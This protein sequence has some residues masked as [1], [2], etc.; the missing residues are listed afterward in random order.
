MT[1]KIKIVTA[2]FKNK[3]I[4]VND[5]K[6]IIS[7]DFQA[8]KAVAFKEKDITVNSAKPVIISKFQPNKPI[9]FKE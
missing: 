8:T 1:D 6:R 7:S 9:K 2:I 5:S 3:D 4:A